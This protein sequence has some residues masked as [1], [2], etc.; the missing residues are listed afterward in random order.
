MRKLAVLAALLAFTGAAAAQDFPTRTMTMIIPFAAGGPTD[1]L[2]RLVAQRMSE[3]LGQT[4]VVENVGGAG[5]M[6]GSKRVADAKP[7]GY[8]FEIGTVGTHAQNQSLYE[9]PLY[10]SVTDFT[11]VAL[12]AEVPIVLIARKDLPVG[13]FKEFVAYAKANQDK[14]H[15]GS[16][17]AGAASHLGCV[18]LNSAMG[19]NITHVPYKGGVLAMQDVIAGRMDFECE[20]MTTVKSHIDAGDVKA[21]AILNE[22]RSPVEPNLPTAVEQGLDVKAYTWNAMFLPKGVQPAIVS[23]LNSAVVQAMKTPAVRDR[24]QSFGAQIVSD[25]RATPDY[26]AGFVK[27]EI[28]K[29][30]APIKASGVTVK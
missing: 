22:T 17:G 18:V 20:I 8:T 14:M 7:D 24:L 13:N 23:K 26:L 25:D 29:W 19:T 9:H 30:E 28:A 1:L 12:I 11:P 27:S 21:L 15:F 4:I 6:A 5:G 2:G 3:I 16:G 10:N